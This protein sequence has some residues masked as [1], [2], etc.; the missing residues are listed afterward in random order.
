MRI[1]VLGSG[2]AF[3]D[4]S[5][6]NSAYLV[7]SG[8]RSFLI[9]C[10]SDALRALQK[11]KVDLFSIDDIFL[12]H[13]HADHSG[14][15]PA[16]LT[17]MHVLDR[18][19]SVRVHVPSTQFEF[20]KTWLAN[21]FIYD[22]RMSFEIALLPID[23]GTKKLNAHLEIEFISTKHLQKYADYTAEAAINPLSFSVIVREGNKSFF[24]SS[25]F[26]SVN[27][28]RSYLECS[29]ALVEATHPTIEEIAEISRRSHDRVFLTH[30]PKELEIGGEWRSELYLKFKV[31]ELNVVHDG[32]VFKI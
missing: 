27:E 18:K 1:T 4:P 25:D 20:V 7:E 17:G 19:D 30:I 9:D 21:F 8:D 11:A 13:L 14:G 12:T 32:Q 3:S 28:V 24:F 23:A 22:R 2:S 10:G 15:L 6:F 29:L 5:R 16:V 26:S 31:E